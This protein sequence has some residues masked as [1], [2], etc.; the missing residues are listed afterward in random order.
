MPTRQVRA[1]HESL[2]ASSI[3][4]VAADASSPSARRTVVLLCTLLGYQGF[5]MAI[6]G[7]AAPWIAKGFGLGESGIARLYTW[8]SFSAIGA[9]VLA[10]LADRV[11]RRRV[12]L[13]CMT[14]TPL[15]A[16]AAAVS[17]SMPVFVLCEIVMYACIAATLAA[18][19]V[20][21]AEELPIA[22]RSTGQSFGGLA[23]GLGGGLCLILMPILDHAGYSWRWL[24]VVS[25]AG[26]VAMPALAWRLPESRRWA[27]AAA[28]GKTQGR[29]FYEVFGSRY[30][31]RAIPILG[32]FLFTS[33]ANTATTSWSYFHG[34]SVVGLSATAASLMMLV[35]GGASMLGFPLGAW[36]S[37]RF[38]RVPTVVTFNILAAAGGLFFYWGPPGWCGVPT[39]W[40]A[41]GFCWFMSAVNAVTV[42]GNSAGTELFPTALRGTMIGWFTLIGAIAAVI[43]QGAIALLAERCGGLSVIVGYLGL[44]SLPSAVVFGVSIQETRG[45]SLE[46]AANEET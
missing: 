10:R 16:F 27:D 44:L 5:T 7:I 18:S 21:L 14:L 29:R 19:V 4:V 22:Q 40:L 2:A 38:G 36:T 32:C 43:A 46:I 35:G 6:N 42:G 31:R 33:I 15:A 45:L 13:W 30:R 39:V 23:V 41:V 37:E 28:R 17:F 12:L 20:V 9:L 26:L 8:I 25:A 3:A 24:L 34:V 1:A 11:G